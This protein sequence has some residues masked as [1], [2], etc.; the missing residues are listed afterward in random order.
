MKRGFVFAAMAAGI[1]LFPASSGASD[2]SCGPNAT[3]TGRSETDGQIT[4]NCRCNDGF[5]PSAEGCVPKAKPA[6]QR[7]Y[8]HSGNGL[9]GG[10]GWQLGYYS[11]VGASAAVKAR[12]R[13]MVREQAK[14]AGVAYEESIDFERYNFVIGLAKETVIWKD[15]ASRVVFEQLRIG[16]ATASHQAAYASLRERQ[17]DELGCHSN[18]AMICLAAL[19]NEDVKAGAVV[20]YGPQITPES[21]E[22]WN[23]LLAEKRITSLKIVVAEN[24]PVPPAALIFS[25]A[26]V[27]SPQAHALAAPLLFKVDRLAGAI[28]QMSPD[29]T[30]ETFAC[31]ASLAS[32][33]CHDMGGYS[34]HMKAKLD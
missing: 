9:I 26:L 25:P 23:W 33:R 21:L 11:P 5:V 30:V 18:G 28:R 10:T 4:L 27:A 1:A 19:M 29:A 8:R 13:E 20:L 15:L 2:E 12:A 16:Q 3:E 7:V 32:L 14:F 22:L 17:F 6:P 34:A 24:D 31:D